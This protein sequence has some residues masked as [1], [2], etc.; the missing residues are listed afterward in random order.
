MEPQQDAPI[1]PE[2]LSFEQ[3]LK[4]L[5]TIIRRLEQGELP[6][7][8]AVSQYKRAEALR[9]R[10]GTLLDNAELAVNQATRGD[11]GMLSSVP[12]DTSDAKP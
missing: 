6:L 10:C 11:D 4:E 3:A 9:A 2:H 8:D 7:E 5:E 12:F 1:L